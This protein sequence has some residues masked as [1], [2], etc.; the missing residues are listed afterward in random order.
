[1]SRIKSIELREGERQALEHEYRIG[2]THSYR[3]RCKGILLK[4]ERRTSAEVARQLGCHEV[5]VNSWLRRY[6]RGGLVG[7]RNLSGRGRK[8]I[9]RGA[10]YRP[11]ELPDAF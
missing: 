7:L 11:R 10:L 1:M 4:S 2:K 5:T 9:G 3:L 6:E 8:P